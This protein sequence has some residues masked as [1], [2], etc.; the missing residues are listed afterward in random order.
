[1]PSRIDTPFVPS[2]AFDLDEPS[3][4]QTADTALSSIPHSPSSEDITTPTGAFFS[5]S[6]SNPTEIF[7]MQE[8]IQNQNLNFS[9]YSQIAKADH[10]TA[11]SILQNQK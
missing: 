3:T 4:S 9:L 10:E 2:S 8:L 6:V 5:P 11:S 7:I 1:M